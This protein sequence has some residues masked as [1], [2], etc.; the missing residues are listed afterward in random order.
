MFIASFIF[1]YHEYDHTQ[2]I[3][4][5]RESQFENL[6]KKY[7]ITVPEELR[8][9]FDADVSSYSSI[10]DWNPWKRLDSVIFFEAS[11]KMNCEN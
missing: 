11:P 4:D 9:E 5:S 2:N 6:I 8:S 10:P 1:M 7:N 3:M